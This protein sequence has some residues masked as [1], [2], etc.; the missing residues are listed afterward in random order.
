[1]GPKFAQTEILVPESIYAVDLVR[2]IIPSPIMIN[3]R[4]P[5]LSTR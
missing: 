3:V 1:M 5:T 2:P 4:R